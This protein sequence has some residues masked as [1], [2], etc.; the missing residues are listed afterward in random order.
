[1]SCLHVLGHST[2]FR[3]LTVDTNLSATEHRLFFHKFIDKM[4]SIRDE[5]IY[6]PRDEAELREVMAWY[7]EKNLPGAA[8]SKDV[9]H[10]KWSACPAGDFNRAK[11]KESYPS[12]AFEVISDFDRRIMGVS[13]AQFGT[14]NDKQIVKTDR[15]VAKIRDDWY[16]NVRWTYFTST[17][18][19]KT[20]VGVYLI[21]NNGY[22]RWPISICPYA[23]AA[24]T[25]L[26][27]YFSTNLESVRKDVECV[28]GIL[29]ERWKILDYGLRFRHMLTGEKVFVTC[30]ILHNMMLDV[31]ERERGGQSR[32]SNPRV[33]R[34]APRAGD[35][36]WIE[37]PSPMPP[38][39]PSEAQL[40]QK[41]A[42]RRMLLAEHLQFSKKSRL[43]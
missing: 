21:C 5:H 22:C 27:G 10:S 37:G 19:V 17:G 40:A 13:S 25:S 32:Q 1:M 31:M 8:G 33:R 29:K 16:A 28:F 23:G 30:C 43:S 14:R 6:L 12:I 18:E 20:E 4:Y 41:W 7:E 9:V 26:E 42:K 36:L 34:G 24:K 3:L 15:N 35:A 39:D 2:P 11:G 38:H